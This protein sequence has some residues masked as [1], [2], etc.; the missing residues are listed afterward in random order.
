MVIEVE[1]KN[2]AAFPGLSR[3]LL[4]PYLDGWYNQNNPKSGADPIYVPY[5]L[6]FGPRTF[7]FPPL[8]KTSL[9]IQEKI[10][11]ATRSS[12][13]RIIEEHIHR[14]LSQSEQ[15]CDCL[16]ESLGMDSLDR[17][18]LALA[19]EQYFHCTSHTAFVPT[20]VGELW[21]LAQGVEVSVRTD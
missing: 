7:D 19:V 1:V 17:M 3:S 10:D 2:T 20:R 8:E 6:F 14:P 5:H 4:N 21:A 11:S 13:N 15:V 9:I 12:V 18:E 16:L